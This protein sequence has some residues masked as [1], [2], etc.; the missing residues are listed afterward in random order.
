[1]AL[2][3]NVVMLRM[4][5]LAPD[6]VSQQR[7]ALRVHVAGQCR[8]T[9]QS[10][11]LHCRLG[12]RLLLSGSSEHSGMALS[13]SSTSLPGGP[14][15]WP[16]HLARGFLRASTPSQNVQSR[17]S[18]AAAAPTCI[19]DPQGQNAILNSFR[20][21]IEQQPRPAQQTHNAGHKRSHL[22]VTDTDRT[23]R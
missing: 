19:A 7:L 13:H 2:L 1:M 10:I 6:R 20:A 17:R 22:V 4:P 15:L 12:Q 18:A 14:M 5:Q 11:G 8:C 9:G 16:A 23:A 3:E 21:A